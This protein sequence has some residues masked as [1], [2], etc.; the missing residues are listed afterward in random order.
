MHSRK[1]L[2]GHDVTTFA[3]LALRLA[4]P[5]DR[6]ALCQSQGL[7]DVQSCYARR[8]IATLKAEALA[9][10]QSAKNR[11]N[12]DA[13]RA[14]IDAAID[15]SVKQPRSDAD[16][17]FDAG[18]VERQVADTYAGRAEQ[19]VGDGCAC[20]SLAGLACSEERHSGPIDDVDVDS[21]EQLGKA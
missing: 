11:K 4:A 13:G 1:R 7:T 12:R 2:Y 21:F 5:T 3:P 18:R 9:L 6:S 20:R 10:R 16:R 17:L 14:G 15:F 19:G 8:P